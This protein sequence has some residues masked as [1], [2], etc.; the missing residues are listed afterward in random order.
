MSRGRADSEGTRIQ[1]EADQVAI[2]VDVVY[3]GASKKG[4]KNKQYKN[5][6]V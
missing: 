6:A 5:T 4:V 3:S 2:M 1:N